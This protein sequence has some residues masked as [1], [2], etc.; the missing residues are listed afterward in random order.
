M[1]KEGLFREAR[2][3]AV[4]G[5]HCVPSLN[6][7]TVGLRRG[8]SNASC[9]TVTVRVTGKGGH[10]AHPDLCVDPVVICAYLLTQLQTV[11]SRENLAT[12]PAVLTF[13]TIHGGTAPNII[14]D[15]V[16]MQGTL[17]TF[18]ETARRQAMNASCDVLFE[19]GMPPLVNT[20][21]LCDLIRLSARRVLGDGAVREDLPPSLGSDDF[22]CIQE[23]CGGQGVQFLLGTRSEAIPNSG[24]GLHVAENIFPD[25]ALLPA[26]ALLSQIAWDYLRK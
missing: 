16:V 1:L 26:A 5:F 8:I 10:G 2:P 17:R 23:A 11:V 25:E 3:D 9:D 13:G 21:A 22:S 24:V 18:D 20:P 15:E 6:L 14:P 12:Q 19:K 7:G 4:I